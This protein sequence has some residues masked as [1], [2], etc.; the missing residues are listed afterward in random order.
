M[1][2]EIDK[3]ITED[4]YFLV[5]NDRN[6]DYGHPLDDFSKTAKFWSVV[7]DKEITPA[8]VALCLSLVKFSRELN[9]PKRDNIV[10][11]IGYLLTYDAVINS[12]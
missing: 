8:Q 12:E 6:T 11:A 4:A 5:S 2:A 1:R 9:K 7:L 10:D 3:S